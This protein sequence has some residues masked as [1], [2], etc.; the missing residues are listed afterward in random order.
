MWLIGKLSH[1]FYARNHPIYRNILFQHVRD[2]A[3]MPSELQ[4]M[5]EKFISGS[6]TGTRGKCQGGDAMLEEL[7]KERKSWLKM[8]GVPSMAK[9]I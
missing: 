8:S 9:S 4:Q 7:N 2:K 1:L 5:M 3:L 6:K